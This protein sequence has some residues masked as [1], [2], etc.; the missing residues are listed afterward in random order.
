MNSRAGQCPRLLSLGVAGVALTEMPK[1]ATRETADD[2]CAD[3]DS[4]L[5]AAFQRLSPCA[6]PIP[7]EA[8]LCDRPLSHLRSRAYMSM[9][10]LRLRESTLRWPRG[11]PSRPPGHYGYASPRASQRP[12]RSTALLGRSGGHGAF[13]TRLSPILYYGRGQHGDRRPRWAGCHL[14]S[15]DGTGPGAAHQRC[16]GSS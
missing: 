8:A 11:W 3:R 14:R 16:Q 1:S 5:H 7:G 2:V 12:D 13:A 4:T 15:S 9:P 6:P 10:A